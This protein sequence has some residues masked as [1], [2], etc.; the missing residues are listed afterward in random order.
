MLETLPQR[1]NGS[2][3]PS[4]LA[5]PPAP[6]PRRQGRRPLKRWRYVGVFGPDVMLCAGVA[7]VAGLRQA[8]WAVWDRRAQR[9]W[10]RTLLRR[11]RVVL[12]DG[13]LRVADREVAIDLVVAP[14]GEPVE[15][16][17]R[18]GASYIWTRKVPLRATGLLTLEGRTVAVDSAGL[19]DDSA[20]YHARRTEWEWSA[21]TGTTA[22]GRAVAWNLVAGVHDD[23][24]ASERTVWVDGTAHEVGPVAFA[25]GLDRV[26]DLR[27]EAEA[28]R[29]RRDD[30]V[31]LASDYRQP[32]GTFAGTLPDGT[33]LASGFGVMER[34]RAR[35]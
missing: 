6:M 15:V 14:A 4:G 9:L 13:A 25:A 21:G 17:S 2:V 3:R 1:G 22:A 12:P 24:A 8:F 18:H 16:T 27:F 20:G 28:E 11:G 31:L 30:L 7:R 33:E 34:H 29:V 10:E 23:P 26:G 19:L 35:W 32:F 5:L